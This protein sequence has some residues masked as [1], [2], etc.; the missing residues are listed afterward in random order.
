MK[1][2]ITTI[3]IALLALWWAIVGVCFPMCLLF[4]F[5]FFTGDL[6]TSDYSLA[7]GY[8]IIFIVLVS[9]FPIILKSRFF[10]TLFSKRPISLDKSA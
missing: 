3:K 7:I 9:L 1:T 6:S 10:N 8:Y 5:Q 4:A 2:I